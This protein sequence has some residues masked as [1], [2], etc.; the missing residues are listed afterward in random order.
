MVFAFWRTPPRPPPRNGQDVDDN[1]S[2]VVRRPGGWSTSEGRADNMGDI[3]RCDQVD[4]TTPWS[5]LGIFY[6]QF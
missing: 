5:V 1:S 3:L 4:N 6:T 2:F